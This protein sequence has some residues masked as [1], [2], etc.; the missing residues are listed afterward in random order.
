MTER[1][2]KASSYRLTDEALAIIQELREPIARALG[3]GAATATDVLERLIRDGQRRYKSATGD[4]CL[5]GTG[6]QRE[7]RGKK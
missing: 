3:I 4:L 6:P 7:G 2:K 5:S 1:H